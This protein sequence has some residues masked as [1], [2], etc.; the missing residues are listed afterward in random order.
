MELRKN[1]RIDYHELVHHPLPRAE[2]H[3]ENCVVW[4][5][6][7]AKSI[8][9]LNIAQSL[10]DL[11]SYCTTVFHDHYISLILDVIEHHI[12]R[13]K[14]MLLIMGSDGLWNVLSLQQAVNLVNS[15]NN[16]SQIMVGR[17]ENAAGLL[18]CL[19]MKSCINGK[20][21]AGQQT[22]LQF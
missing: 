9:L 14:D 3:R 7:N 12:N 18:I 17:R 22:T 5:R 1:I 2:R 8:P 20:V 15:S 10:R 19:S 16:M 11:W 4:Q 13:H 6:C 21:K